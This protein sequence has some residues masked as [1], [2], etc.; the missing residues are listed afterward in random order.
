MG[1]GD[2]HHGA[3][4]GGAGGNAVKNARAFFT[5]LAELWRKDRREQEMEEEFASVMEMEAEAN[6]RAGMSA[7]EA[8]RAARMK[9]G[10]E[11]TKEQVRDRRGLPLLETVIQD[12]KFGWRTLW[13]NP[14][15]T[16]VAVIMLALG[17][18]ANTA[19]FSAVDA[20]LLRAFP[21]RQPQQLVAIWESSGNLK[22]LPL[23]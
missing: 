15:F 4:R 7:E 21:Y 20:V 1:A 5:R 10:L 17:I 9:L 23:L 19:M 8:R 16:A 13:K 12:T 6:V 14:G 22:G 2:N 3:V 11:A 18:G